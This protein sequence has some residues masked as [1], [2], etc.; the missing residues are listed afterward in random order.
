M[1]LYIDRPLRTATLHDDTCSHAPRPHGTEFKPLGKLG[2]DGGWFSVS[3]SAKARVVAQREFPQVRTS[4]VSIARTSDMPR[5]VCG[6]NISFK[7]DG[8]AAAQ[9]QR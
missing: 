2:R 3:S 8:C 5:L 7:A 4:H 6:S 9:L 1:L